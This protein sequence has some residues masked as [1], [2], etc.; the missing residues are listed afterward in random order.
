MKRSFSSIDIPKLTNICSKETR[1]ETVNNRRANASSN[2][3]P[4]ASLIAIPKA[5]N[6]IIYIYIYI[7]K[8]SMP[9]DE[10]TS[11]RFFF[12]PPTWAAWLTLPRYRLAIVPKNTHVY[13]FVRYNFDLV[14]NLSKIPSSLAFHLKTR[15]LYFSI[16]RF[17]NLYEVPSRLSFRATRVANL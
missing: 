13:I 16:W 17:P 5:A 11:I 10:I 3:F 8:N 9:R 4:F 1:K 6:N 14:E 2:V 15:Q 12:L 7:S